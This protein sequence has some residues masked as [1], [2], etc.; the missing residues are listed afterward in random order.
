MRISIMIINLFCGIGALFG[1]ILALSVNNQ[2]I[3]GVSQSLLKNAPFKTF[4]IP[5]LVLILIIGL[6]NFS[7]TYLLIIN[8][9]YAAASLILLGIIQMGF[10][11]IQILMLFGANPLHLIF[12]L[13]GLYQAIAGVSF[14]KQHNQQIPFS[15]KQN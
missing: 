14:L 10:I 2:T 15:A 7:V 12:F 11:L 4:L 3:M 6:G 13:I 5:A 8:H 9:Q 1:G